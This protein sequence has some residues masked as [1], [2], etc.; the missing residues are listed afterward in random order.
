MNP[1]GNATPVVGTRIL[2]SELAKAKVQ[3]LLLPR[4]QRLLTM[5]VANAVAYY[6]PAPHTGRSQ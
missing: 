2:N 5:A 4:R 3:T 6:T 1:A